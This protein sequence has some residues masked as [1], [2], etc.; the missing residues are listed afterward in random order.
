MPAPNIL[1]CRWVHQA[2]QVAGCVNTALMSLQGGHLTYASSTDCW[3]AWRLLPSHLLGYADTRSSLEACL[4]LWQA[5]LDCSGKLQTV[6]VMGA[7]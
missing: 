3:G 7:P 6:P 4:S 1:V 2:S 5:G